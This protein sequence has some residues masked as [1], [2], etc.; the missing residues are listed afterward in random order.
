VAGELLQLVVEL[1]LLGG[2]VAVQPPNSVVALIQ[3][4]GLVRLVQFASGSLFHR[5][6]HVEDVAL[7]GI[8]RAYAQ[9]YLMC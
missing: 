8:S 5:L 1:L 2:G 9:M 4:G 7:Q 3:D 6:L